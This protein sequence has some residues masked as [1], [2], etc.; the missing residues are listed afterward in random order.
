MANRSCILILWLAATSAAA[1]PLAD[2]GNQQ[3]STIEHSTTQS[4]RTIHAQ[5]KAASLEE[6]EDTLTTRLRRIIDELKR[7]GPP[8]I[9]CMEG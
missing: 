9:G 2:S 1:A 6:S 8:P 7:A 4:E 3:Q 5:E